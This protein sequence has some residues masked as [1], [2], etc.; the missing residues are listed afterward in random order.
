MKHGHRKK[1]I[2]EYIK[3][4]TRERGYAPTVQEIADHVGLTS[5]SSVHRHLNE[6]EEFGFIE[7]RS[8]SPRAIRVVSGSG[9]A[10]NVLE[11]LKQLDDD[12]TDI[13]FIHGE[14]FLVKRATLDDIKEWRG[15]ES[16]SS[17]N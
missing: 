10:A 9:P 17:S 13:I 6:L 3:E 15:E 16:T 11:Q 14:P 1:E 5:T 2:L 7:K 4:S 8:H 12:T